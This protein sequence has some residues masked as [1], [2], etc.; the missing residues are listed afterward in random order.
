MASNY[1]ASPL[2]EDESGPL[3]HE[4]TPV[5]DYPRTKSDPNLPLTPIAPLQPYQQP[6]AA[7]TSPPLIPRA[8][9]ESRN[10][11]LAILIVVFRM[12]YYWAASLGLLAVLVCATIWFY[13]TP[14]GYFWPIWVML[15]VAIATL[16]LGMINL[17]MKGAT[18]LLPQG[19]REQLIEEYR[20][21]VKP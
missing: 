17:V 18:L 12:L 5:A 15:G 21:R 11:A 1:Q 10:R 19:E 14:N 13:A 6:A 20:R 9:E 2:S 7:P 3:G 4:G 8:S 16:V